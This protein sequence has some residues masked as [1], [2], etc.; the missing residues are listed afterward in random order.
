LRLRAEIDA[1]YADLYGLDPDDFDWI[2]PDEPTDPKGFYRVDRGPRFRERLTVLAATA[3]RAWKEGR[4]SARSADGLSNDA[5]FA[6]LGMPELTDAETARARGRS[7][8]LILKRDGCHVWRPEV[9]PPKDFRE[10]A[11]EVQTVSLSI[12]GQWFGT[13]GQG[14]SVLLDALPCGWL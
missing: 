3:S 8:P 1:L 2:V 14:R 9:F 6:L 5:F 12:P 7:G 10:K 11:L 4:G 13:F